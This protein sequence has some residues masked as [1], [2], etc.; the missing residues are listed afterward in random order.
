MSLRQD[1]N[2]FG[3]PF[4][5]LS[6]VGMAVSA[7]SSVVALPNANFG[8]TMVVTNYG[9]AAAFVEFSGTSAS[10]AA[11]TASMCILPNAAYTL[12][13][14]GVASPEDTT[15]AQWV[16]VITSTGTTNLQIET[17]FGL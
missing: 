14:P 4:E 15:R 16:A 8:S 11:T 7:T 5:P 6:G 2:N 3:R 17:G 13:R 1:R 9:S 10:L 12:T